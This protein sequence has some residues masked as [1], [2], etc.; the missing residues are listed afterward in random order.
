MQDRNEDE[1]FRDLASYVMAQGLI[2]ELL[3]MRYLKLFEGEIRDEVA[4]TIIG[5]GNETGAFDG[6]TLPFEDAEILSDVA[7]R[8]RGQLAALVALAMGRAAAEDAERSPS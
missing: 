1:R 3:L 8:M 5:R 2:V 7:V 6:L 4:K